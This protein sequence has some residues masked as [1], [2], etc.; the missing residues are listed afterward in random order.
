[1]NSPLPIEVLKNIWSKIS[2]INANIRSLNEELL[3]LK[4][5]VDSGI[6]E[7]DLSKFLTKDFLFKEGDVDKNIEIDKGHAGTEKTS[8]YLGGD[9]QG[10]EQLNDNKIL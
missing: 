5:Y 8:I 9:Y 10:N 6:S 3:L 7:I 4:N 1:M 2:E